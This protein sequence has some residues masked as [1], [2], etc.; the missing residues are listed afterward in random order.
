MGAAAIL[1]RMR[2]YRRWGPRV[3]AHLSPVQLGSIDL[4]IQEGYYRT[5]S[6]FLA[7]AVGAYL[8]QREETVTALAGRRGFSVGRVVVGATCEPVVKVIGVAVIE[9]AAVDRLEQ[10]VVF[11]VVQ[12][13]PE[14]VEA[15]GA[16]LVTHAVAEQYR[17]D[18]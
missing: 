1:A 13:A 12:A 2:R 7:A 3:V 14:V 10:I 9:E 8:R 4:L 18:D 15:L 17:D 16:R 6:G 5:R 11:G